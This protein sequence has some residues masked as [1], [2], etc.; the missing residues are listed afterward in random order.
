[1]SSLIVQKFWNL[2]V[3]LRIERNGVDIL[4]STTL[5]TT[6]SRRLQH[7]RNLRNLSSVHP[8]TNTAGTQHSRLKAL[9]VGGLGVLDLLARRA[10]PPRGRALL[11]R[12]E[13]VVGAWG[14]VT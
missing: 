8:S 9:G 6:L 5:L 3:G 7:L 1:M 13:I 10:P 11:H 4:P 14:R 2:V 12:G